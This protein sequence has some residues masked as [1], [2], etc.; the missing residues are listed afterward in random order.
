VASSQG[1]PQGEEDEEEVVIDYTN[2]RNASADSLTSDE[3]GAGG[4]RNGGEK[5]K[6]RRFVEGQ[7]VY[8][9]NPEG[10]I[11]KVCIV[12]SDPD[13]AYAI[14]LPMGG[15]TE[16]V[17]ASRLAT[18]TEL[19]SKELS[20]LMRERN[21]R[22]QQRDHRGNRRG[23]SIKSRRGDLGDG[24]PVAADQVVD[25]GYE[26]EAGEPSSSGSERSDPSSPKEGTAQAAGAATSMALVV[27]PTMQMVQAKTESGEFKTVPLYEAG[28]VVRYKNAAGVVGCT[29]LKVHLDDLLDPYYDVRLED[30]R[31]KQT[32]NAHIM[33][34]LENGEE[35]K[36]EKEEGGE[37][38]VSK[39]AGEEERAEPEQQHLEKEEEE[40]G[41]EGEE[42]RH[43]YVVVEERPL[44]A[45]PESEEA[46]NEN[47]PPS[48]PKKHHLPSDTSKSSNETSAIPVREPQEKD[49]LKSSITLPAN[50]YSVGDEVL[51]KSSEGEPSR[52]VVVKTRTDKKQRPYYV[53]RLPQG[54]EKQVYGHRL[55]PLYAPEED[56]EK[57]RERSRAAARDRGRSSSKFGRSSSRKPGDPP[58]R[59]ESIDS[60]KSNLTGSSRR[61]RAS[62]ERSV[63]REES[64]GSSLP[65]G[66]GRDE[67]VASSSSRGGGHRRGREESISSSS[68]NTRRDESL[69][70]SRKSARSQSKSASARPSRGRHM[71]STGEGSRVRGPSEDSRA[72]QASSAHHHQTPRG[73]SRT[74]RQGTT[75][76]VSA[77]SKKM[78]ALLPGFHGEG[79]GEGEHQQGDHHNQFSA[80]HHHHSM[81]GSAGGG[82][83]DH[84]RTSGRSISKL[85]SFRK[86][87][88]SMKKQR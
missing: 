53:V 41:G 81:S 87:F 27:P 19:T 70:S 2:D 67:S 13:G 58:K 61:S 62:R 22:Q 16:D 47:D 8:Y 77:S 71:G 74:R 64:M 73:K 57:G 15:I 65:R 85:K 48:S 68:R 36:E 35:E 28:M 88:A 17:R 18:L 21:K 37:E 55:R 5:K 79:G 52:A 3:E 76:S 40:G 9:R 20:M 45:D 75:P 82:G 4:P 72:S 80:P 23:P 86:S 51:Y 44:P 34:A 11:T 38:E 78:M 50:T 14:A 69:A 30:G 63:A 56:R 1:H 33:L 12:S 84:S 26:A 66:R 83:D 49:P 25:E 32:D 39:E 31:E 10:G 43:K 42:A 54:K 7:D 59:S 29:I 24:N 6:R 46:S 60:R